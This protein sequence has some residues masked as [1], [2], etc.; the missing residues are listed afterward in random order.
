MRT[1]SKK[2]H[3]PVLVKDLVIRCSKFQIELKKFFLVLL[4]LFP[5]SISCA[6][7]SLEPGMPYLFHLDAAYSFAHIPSVQG[8]INPS[9]YKTNEN[10]LILGGWMSTMTQLE[11]GVLFEFNQTNLL[12]FNLESGGLYLKK[13]FLDDL[14]GDVLGFDAGGL[15]QFVPKNRLIDPVT[16]YNA[17]ANFSLLAEIYKNFLFHQD[18]ASIAPFLGVDLGI[19]NRGYPWLDPVVGSRLSYDWFLAEVA[20]LGNFGFG[21]NELIDLANFSGYAFTAYRTVDIEISMGAKILDE[22]FFQLAYTSRLYAQA[23]PKSRQALLVQLDLPIP[24][25]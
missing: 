7:S 6:L 12:P 13:N 5:S 14:N 10:K 3:L 20:F 15:M 8:A 18:R 17:V 25:F 21:P 16:P 23:S 2:L 11:L 9:Y 1:Q 24:L 19:A 22:G 4:A